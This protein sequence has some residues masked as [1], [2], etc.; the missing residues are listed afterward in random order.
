VTSEQLWAS[1]D[2]LTKP[3]HV[4]LWRDDGATEC[5]TVPSLW[6]QLKEA[7]AS[8]NALDGGG[9]SRY[10]TPL[11]L[12]CLELAQTIAETVVDALAGHDQKPRSDVPS[13]LRA[14][15][16][17]VT[18]TGD[19]DLVGWWTYRV[20]SWCRQ[21]RAALRLDEQPLP[22]GIRGTRCPACAESHAVVRRDDEDVRV[23]ALVVDFTED[24][25]IRAAECL[26]CGAAWF[27]GAALWQLADATRMTLYADPA[28]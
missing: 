5:T 19:D 13:S 16:S 12:T 20:R 7:V 28:V 1:V 14:L 23:S 6:W 2:E 4:K 15:G 17:A 24:G 21:I 26:R 27:R 18:R 9:G 3:R 11:D 8:S 25:L 22:R 10:R